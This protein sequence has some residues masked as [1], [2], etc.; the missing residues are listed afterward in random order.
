MRRGG[1]LRVEEG[2]GEKKKKRDEGREEKEKKKREKRKGGGKERKERWKADF[3]KPRK[4]RRVAA[5]GKGW[6]K[7]F[8]GG[9]PRVW[10]LGGLWPV[11]ATLS[12]SQI[13]FFIEN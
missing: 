6:E 4:S 2:H 3:A 9:N 1:E 5:K 10:R 8:P 11:W 13:F 7:N 12:L